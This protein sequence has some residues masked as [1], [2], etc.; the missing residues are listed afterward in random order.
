MSARQASAAPRTGAYVPV[1]PPPP[2]PAMCV[3]VWGA[4]APLGVA[5]SV[6]SGTSA[7]TA[8]SVTSATC[9]GGA[10]AAAPPS[11]LCSSSI[12]CSTPTPASSAS[13]GGQ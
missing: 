6:Q 2:P 7:R 3:G 10:S 4:A 13:G 12:V 8:R 11:R 9:G 5:R 1:L